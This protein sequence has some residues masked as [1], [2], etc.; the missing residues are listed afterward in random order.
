M[1]GSVPPH[2]DIAFLDYASGWNV[3]ENCY[4][5]DENY[6]FHSQKKRV[7]LTVQIAN[8]SLNPHPS[9]NPVRPAGPPALLSAAGSLRR[10][11]IA[12]L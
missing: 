11:V 7:T 1:C 9:P 5:K 6:N 4:V 10:S 2:A 12:R 3:G 8:P